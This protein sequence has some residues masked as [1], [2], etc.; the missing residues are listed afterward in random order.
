VDWTVFASF[1]VTSDGTNVIGPNGK[2]KAAYNPNLTG[3]NG[4][5]YFGGDNAV[6]AYGGRVPL[7]TPN[8]WVQGSSMGHLDDKTFTGTNEKMMNARTGKGPGV[9]ILSPI[10]LGILKDLGYTVTPNT[11]TYAAFMFVGVIFLRRP[12]RSSKS[13]TSAKQA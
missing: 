10:E 5:L 7:Y 13:P 4:G 11:P 8:P 2:W 1:V 9:R 12:K 3:G 6:D